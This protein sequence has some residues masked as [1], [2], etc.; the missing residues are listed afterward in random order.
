MVTYDEWISGGYF[1]WPDDGMAGLLDNHIAYVT[2]ENGDMVVYTWAGYSW[3]PKGTVRDT[4]PA[5]EE[6]RRNAE[7]P[8]WFLEPWPF[9]SA[10]QIALSDWRRL[11]SDYLPRPHV[12]VTNQ[13]LMDGGVPS[14]W[15][16]VPAERVVF[17]VPEEPS[18]T[19]GGGLKQKRRGG[20]SKRRKS[21]RRKTK[22]RKSKRSKRR[23]SKKK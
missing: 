13:N 23:K 11:F 4:D 15:A 5:R 22:R 9:Y 16:L 7:D 12:D 1:A 20:K 8:D 14:A 6:L 3:N 21:K 18:M 2:E 19:G 17:D 10:Q